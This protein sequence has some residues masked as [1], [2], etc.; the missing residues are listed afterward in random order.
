MGNT[1]L[2]LSDLTIEEKQQLF[3]ALQLALINNST[4][5][6]QLQQMFYP[7]REVSPDTVEFTSIVTVNEISITDETRCYPRIDAFKNSSDLYYYVRNTDFNTDRFL[8]SN[9]AFSNFQAKLTDY[10]NSINETLEELEYVSYHIIM[11]IT[12]MRWSTPSI[13]L[14]FYVLNF[15]VDKLDVMPC[16]EDYVDAMS[17]VLSWVS[18][19]NYQANS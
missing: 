13:Y 16:E 5:L 18:T 3:D 2:V 1:S 6:F 8:V 11:T 15:E 9:D 17:A 10:V 14:D 19:A 7:P 4:N 12:N